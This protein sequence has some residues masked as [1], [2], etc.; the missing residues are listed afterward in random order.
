MAERLGLLVTGGSDFHGPLG[1]DLRPGM[2]CFP[3]PDFL[4]LEAAAVTRRAALRAS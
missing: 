3:E 1:Q 2:L 4:R